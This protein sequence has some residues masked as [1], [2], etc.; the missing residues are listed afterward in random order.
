MPLVRVAILLAGSGA[1]AF[2]PDSWLRCLAALVVGV[3]FY[4]AAYREARRDLAAE[5]LRGNVRGDG[6]GARSGEAEGG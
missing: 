1:V 4:I 5:I 3:L 6:R 2:A